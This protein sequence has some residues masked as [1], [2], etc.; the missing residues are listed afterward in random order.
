M[1]LS[2]CVVCCGL[3]DWQTKNNV[4]YFLIIYTILYYIIL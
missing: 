2:G 1:M 3:T 4:Y